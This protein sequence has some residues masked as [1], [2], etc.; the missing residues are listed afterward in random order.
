[1][2]GKLVHNCCFGVG[3]QGLQNGLAGPPYNTKVPLKECKRIVKIYRDTHPETVK[4][5]REIEDAVKLAIKEGKP[6]TILNGRVK[7]GQVKTAGLKYFVL[8]LPSGRRLYYP[9]PKIKP[10][11]VEYTIKEMAEEEWKAKQG[12]YWRDEIRFWGQRPNNAGWGWIATYGS[13]LFENIVQATGADLLDEGC[14]S[15]TEAGFDIFLIVH[16]QSLCYAHP[17]KSLAEFEKAFCSVGEW[18]RT[19]PLAADGAVVPYYL[20]ELD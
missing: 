14:I 12:G 9:S 16:D 10:K 5:W 13:R 15:A 2:N 4:A 3:G 7:V 6:S 11:W 17:T 8:Q 20:K 19:F 18:A 1:M